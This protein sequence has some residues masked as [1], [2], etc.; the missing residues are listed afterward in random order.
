MQVLAQ[1]GHSAGGMVQRQSDV[2]DVFMPHVG[3]VMNGTGKQRVPGGLFKKYSKNTRFIHLKSDLP[4]MADDSSFG[5][6]GGAGRVNVQ[7]FVFGIS[8]LWAG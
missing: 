7:H 1:A 6:S 8:A 2:N 4:T 5:Q 3:H